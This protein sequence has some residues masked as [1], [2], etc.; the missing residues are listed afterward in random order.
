MSDYMDALRE[1]VEAHKFYPEDA[2]QR[3]E[4]GSAELQI[5]IM[6]DGTVRNLR[7]LASS[8]SPALDAA[9]M[10]VFRD[11]KLPPF[12]DDMPMRELTM[13][14]TLNYELIYRH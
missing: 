6:R 4:Q 14:V 3:G 1:F 12:N 7:Q 8:G 2:A 10:S 11:N 13:P 9:W 5:T